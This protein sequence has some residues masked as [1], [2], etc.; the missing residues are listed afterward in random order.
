MRLTLTICI[1]L[2]YQVVFSQV[3]DTVDVAFN[4]TVILVFDNEI[5][6]ANPGSGDVLIQRT[7]DKL[8]LKIRANIYHFEETNLLIETTGGLYAYILRYNEDPSEFYILVD[9]KKAIDYVPGRERNTERTKGS[10]PIERLSANNNR[11]NTVITD[12]EGSQM[13]TLVADFKRSSGNYRSLAAMDSKMILK[14]SNI[15][16]HEDFI[17]FKINLFNNSYLPYKVNYWRYTIEQRGKLFG[18]KT[19]SPDVIN[20]VYDENNFNNYLEGGKEGEIVLVFN[21]FT[22][23]KDSELII[24]VKED[25]GN[26]DLSLSIDQKTILNINKF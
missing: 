13:E 4:K 15:M 18:N 21:T 17:F 1:S 22:F 3:S 16:A 5:V 2:L 12:I 10:D 20:P 7:Q 23:E 11:G 19:D 14:V 26:R 9:Y 6:D 8:K 25:K 24:E